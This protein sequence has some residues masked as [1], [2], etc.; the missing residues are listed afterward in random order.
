[1]REIFEE[2]SVLIENGLNSVMNR[3]DIVILNILAL[4]VLLVFV[5]TFLWKRIT[6]FINQRQKALTEALENADLEREIAKSLQ[7]KSHKDYEAMREETRILKE[8]LTLEAYK[9]QEE[10]ITSAKKEAKRRLDQADKDIEF[11]IIQAN[12]QIKQSIKEIA[13]A[14]AEKI[15]KREI[16]ENVHQDII[17]DIVQEREVR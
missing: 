5:R 11:E 15:V 1:M 2:V 9:Q 10:L 17:D 8:K 16:D 6:D 14:A 13:F 12:E 7:E 3:P 4:I